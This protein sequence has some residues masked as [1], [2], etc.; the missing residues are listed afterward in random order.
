MQIN[1]LAYYLTDII[2]TWYV[3][4]YCTAYEICLAVE[5]K[6]SGAASG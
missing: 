5:G 1:F 4:G 2:W 3:T 6:Y